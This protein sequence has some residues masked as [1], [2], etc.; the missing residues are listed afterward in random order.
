MSIAGGKGPT[1][2]DMPVYINDLINDGIV[3]MTKQIQVRAQQTTS[4]PAVCI[5]FM[6]NNTLSSCC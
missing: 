1:C 4:P 3:A 5:C 6:Y 2:G